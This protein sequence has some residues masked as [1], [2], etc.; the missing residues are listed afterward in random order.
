MQRQAV[1]FTEEARLRRKSRNRKIVIGFFVFIGLIVL[2]ESPLT[3]VRGFSVSG[4]RALPSSQL[5]A[6]TN[7]RTGMS[8]WQISQGRIQTE[9]VE[10][11][12]LVQGVK[13]HIDW[14]HGVVQL[15]IT[16]KHV[17]ALYEVGAK[18][19]E[20]LND[21]V[22]YGAASVTNGF[23]FPIVTTNDQAP[24]VLGRVVNTDVGT[25]CEQIEAANQDLLSNVSEIHV[26]GDGTVS[27]YLDDGFAA[28]CQTAQLK[29]AL[30]SILSAVQYFS[31]KGYKPGLID[32]TGAPPYRYTPFSR[33]SP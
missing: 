19:Y 31:G 30:P 18:F 17:V 2:L 25:V 13:V 1:G 27:V 14:L 23:A 3:R 29:S 11:E 4:N 22:V 32:L 12:P 9:L 20:L 8:L 6:D 33:Q 10:R 5:I 16:E 21:G 28:L 26:N 24:A 15:N 7:L